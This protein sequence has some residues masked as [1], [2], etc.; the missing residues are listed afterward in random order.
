M[1][2]FVY[3]TLMIPEV[4]RRVTGQSFQAKE[5]ILRGYARFLVRDETY[6]GLMPFPD[7][8]TE[9]VVYYDLDE[10]AVRLL[11]LFEGDMYERVEVNVEAED[12]SWVEAET[13]IVRPRQRKRLTAKSW[14]EDEFRTRHLAA[15]LRDYPGFAHATVREA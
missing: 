12:H 5:G 3:G 11:D 6:P 2:L 4:M 8:E 9:G 14:D 10:D 7:V 1:H 13:Y 15:F